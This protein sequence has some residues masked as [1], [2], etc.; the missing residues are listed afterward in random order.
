MALWSRSKAVVRREG[1]SGN[2]VRPDL[3]RMSFLLSARIGGVF[4]IADGRVELAPEGTVAPLAR[5]VT[6]S[7]ATIVLPGEVVASPRRR[8]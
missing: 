7:G 5:V 3:V 6:A 2:G 4:E 1:V 8:G